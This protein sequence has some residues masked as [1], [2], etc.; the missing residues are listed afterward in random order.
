[1]KKGREKSMI[2]ALHRSLIGLTAILLW[3][4]GETQSAGVTE[5]GNAKITGMVLDSLGS[6]VAK[7]YIY[8]RY[9]SYIVDLDNSLTDSLVNPYS[10]QDVYSDDNG[11]FAFD[12]VP[13]G[14][15]YIECEQLTFSSVQ[16]IEIQANDS[17]HLV[18]SISP[19]GNISGTLNEYFIKDGYRYVKIQGL[20]HYT[21]LDSTTGMF[22]LDGVPAGSYRLHF[23]GD[24]HS[25]GGYYDV[26][27]GV[28]ENVD[29][30]EI[31]LMRN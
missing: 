6:P 19:S 28:G 30:G 29:L 4:C 15:Y 20:E 5:G 12:S 16:V 24:P 10:V 23:T 26:T 7:A 2:V 27:V 8:L 11:H 31:G 3:A 9:G 25:N 22:V 1:M 14:E 18:D 17:I 21:T 13:A